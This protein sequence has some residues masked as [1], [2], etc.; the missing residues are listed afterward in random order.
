MNDRNWQEMGIVWLTEK[1][2]K[3]DGNTKVEMHG[4]AYIPQ[5][6]DVSAAVEHFG[7]DCIAGALNGTSWRVAAQDVNRRLKAA[8][9]SE[10]AIKDAIYNRIK[11]IR[12]T[13]VG[14]SRTVVVYKLPNGTSY[15]GTDLVEYQQAFI[16]ALV[17]LG[18]DNATT[19]A[20]A[21]A[22]TL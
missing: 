13:A 8:G 11:G 2:A 3:R 9:Q 20:K 6:V 22:L 12:N 21:Q 5:V 10:D 14:G 17:D 19:I 15:S 16:A 18:V 4:D 7:N 1:V